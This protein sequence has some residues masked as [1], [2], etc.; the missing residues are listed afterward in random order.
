M[1]IEYCKYNFEW[2]FRR[3][4][5][6]VHYERKGC[7]LRKAKECANRKRYKSTWPHTSESDCD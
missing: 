6:I 1:P 4:A 3:A 2:P 5:W 7:S